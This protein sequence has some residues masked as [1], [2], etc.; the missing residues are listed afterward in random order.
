MCRKVT[1]PFSEVFEAEAQFIVMAEELGVLGNFRQEDLSHL[2]RTLCDRQH[3]QVHIHKQ[4]E[5]LEK[6]EN[7]TFNP[8][9]T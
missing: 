3:V 4:A 2:Q 7:K 5:I 8:K 6:T 1:P 9:V